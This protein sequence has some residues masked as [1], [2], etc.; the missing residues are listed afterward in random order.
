MHSST[1]IV[2]LG[3]TQGGK[4]ISF[5][6]VTLVI[7]GMNRNLTRELISDGKSQTLTAYSM[8]VAL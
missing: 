8:L 3:P 2:H 7:V 6:D 4:A 1:E 5:L